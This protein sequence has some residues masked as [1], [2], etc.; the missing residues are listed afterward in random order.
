MKKS[1]IKIG[2]DYT[3]AAARVVRRVIWIERDDPRCSNQDHDVIYE[4]VEGRCDKWE[5]Y[6]GQPDSGHPYRS[7]M[8]LGGFARWAV[9]EDTRFKDVT[10]ARSGRHVPRIQH[11]VQVR[12]PEAARWSALMTDGG[13]VVVAED[14]LTAMWL[15]NEFAPVLYREAR[16]RGEVALGGDASRI[17]TVMR[18]SK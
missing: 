14:A 18:E 12:A 1:D 15:A 10:R 11:V 4:V 13:D 8:T 2:V 16:D 3:N 6:R 17:R 9:Q 7:R 5:R